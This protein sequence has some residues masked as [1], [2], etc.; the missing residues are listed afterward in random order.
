MKNH[1][2]IQ[3]DKVLLMQ[4]RMEEAKRE[5]EKKEKVDMTRPFGITVGENENNT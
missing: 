5:K 3:V 1:G 4:I 2:L